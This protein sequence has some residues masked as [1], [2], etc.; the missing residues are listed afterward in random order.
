MIAPPLVDA[1]DAAEANLLASLTRKL[2]RFGFTCSPVRCSGGWRL[3]CGA[4]TL[5]AASMQ[6]LQ[7]LAKTGGVHDVP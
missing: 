7:E 2:E 1:S 3:V 5:H 4:R 6:R